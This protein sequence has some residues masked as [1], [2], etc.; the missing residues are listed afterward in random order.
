V[1]GEN[2][3]ANFDLVLLDI[4]MPE[5]SGWEAFNK[6]QKKKNDCKVVFISILEL[7]E[8]RKNNLIDKGLAGYINKPFSYD[9]LVETVNT[10]LL[11]PNV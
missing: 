7:S 11:K 2:E 1:F 8:K 10:I 3:K 6:I 5:M 4:M 9:K